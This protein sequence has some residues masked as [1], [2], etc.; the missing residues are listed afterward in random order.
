MT[1]NRDC[2]KDKKTLDDIL[3]KIEN[4][5]FLPK[6][7]NADNGLFPHQINGAELDKILANLC[8]E[9][10]CFAEK[11]ADGFSVAEKN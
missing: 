6:I 2:V 10:P 8:K 7:L 5:D 11:E 1:E 9:Y 3:F 4:G